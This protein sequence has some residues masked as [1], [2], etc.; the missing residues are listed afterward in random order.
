MVG[1]GT[2]NK[3]FQTQQEHTFRT[4]NNLLTLQENPV[5]E[6]FEYH[7][8]EFLA[9]LEK[10]IEDTIE[11]TVSQMLSKLEFTLN[12]T[13]N[14]I[15]LVQSCL[16][17]FEKITRENIDLDLQNLL[18]SAINSEVIAQRKMA[19]QSYLESQGFAPS[20][21]TPQQQMQQQPMQQPMNIQ[22]QPQMGGMNQQM[23]QQQM[24]MNNQSGYPVAPMGYDQYNNPYW[25]DPATGQIT[26]TPPQ[27]GLHLG[28]KVAKAAAWAKWLA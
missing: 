28:Q 4:V 9:A 23:Q 20:S 7:G 3:G 25:N 5:E 15:T 21:V 2:M 24:A 12:T 14:S 10:L 8:V 13:S 18:A 26:Y 11:S 1:T 16:S 27:S 22:G 6:F 17:D 19:K